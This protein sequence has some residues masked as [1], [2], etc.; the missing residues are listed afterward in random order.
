MR[1]GK[2][3][4]PVIYMTYTGLKWDVN[5]DLARLAKDFA[6]IEAKTGGY[7]VAQIGLP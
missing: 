7:C 2:E 3:Y 6:E 5:G 1:I 4:A